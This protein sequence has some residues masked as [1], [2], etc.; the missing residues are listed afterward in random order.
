MARDD[1]DRD[2]R[3]MKDGRK[4]TGPH[5]DLGRKKGRRRHS[6]RKHRGRKF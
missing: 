3:G 5:E 4:D 6:A 2:F 1:A